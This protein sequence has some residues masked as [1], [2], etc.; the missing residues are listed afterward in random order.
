MFTWPFTCCYDKRQFFVLFIE[1]MNRNGL[2][3]S[4]IF[5]ELLNDDVLMMIKAPFS[6]CL[7]N[8][9]MDGVIVIKA[10]FHFI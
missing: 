9:K 3:I 10:V 4:V 8:L 5:I 2:M 1:L 6:F 7:W